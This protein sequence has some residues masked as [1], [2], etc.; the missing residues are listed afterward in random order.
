MQVVLQCT[1][2]QTILEIIDDGIG[3]KSNEISV[4]GMGPKNMRERAAIM[5]GT[6]TIESEPEKGTT[7]RVTSEVVPEFK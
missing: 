7:V 3:F 4:G 6:L 2:G 1:T 5:G